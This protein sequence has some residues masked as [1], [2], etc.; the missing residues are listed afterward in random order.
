MTE[1]AVTDDGAF[2]CTCSTDDGASKCT[3]CFKT[4]SKDDGTFKC[5][6]FMTV[7]QMMVH[8]S[9]LHVYDM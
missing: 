7:A 8:P 1:A 6:T 4:C 9:V 5:T 2:K 3:T